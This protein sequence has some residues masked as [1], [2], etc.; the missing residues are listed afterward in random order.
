M[1]HSKILYKPNYKLNASKKGIFRHSR[2]KY[3][4]LQKTPGFTPLKQGSR[5]KDLDLLNRASNRSSESIFR[6]YIYGEDAASN[7]F[8]LFPKGGGL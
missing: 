5:P 2:S 3:T 8:G 4:L 6:E 7:Y 1:P